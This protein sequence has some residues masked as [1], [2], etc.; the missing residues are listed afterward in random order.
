M[1]ECLCFKDSES[2]FV[3]RLRQFDNV[4]FSGYT[5]EGVS[6]CYLKNGILFIRSVAICPPVL[7]K[8][9]DEAILSFLKTLR[10]E[11]RQELY[12]D[13]NCIISHS[14]GAKCDNLANIR[15]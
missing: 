5:G 13:I 2:A 15:S 11:Q 6:V 4:D 14:L 3:E 7:R 10:P 12:D 8:S 9:S 1:N